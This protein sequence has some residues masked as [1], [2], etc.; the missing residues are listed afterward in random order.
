M[1]ESADFGVEGLSSERDGAA[2][3]WFEATEGRAAARHAAAVV[4]LDG[5]R[6]RG[7][8]ADGRDPKS[9]QPNLAMASQ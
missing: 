7:E 8:V 3:P 1:A 5:P 9:G 4:V 6:E 2:E